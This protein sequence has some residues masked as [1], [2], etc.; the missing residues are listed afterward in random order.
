M[1]LKSFWTTS[2]RRVSPQRR[3][4]AASLAERAG[5]SIYQT[6]GIRI[7]IV[8]DYAFQQTFTALILKQLGHQVRIASDVLEALSALQLDHYDVILLDCQ[9]PLMSGAT[10]TRFIRTLARMKGQNLT[11][12]GISSTDAPQ[13]CFDAGMDD[14]VRKP[15]NKAILKAV[16]GRS[17]RHNNAH[18]NQLYKK[19]LTHSQT[20]K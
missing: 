5:K 13:E 6:H 18:M 20:S 2:G 8:E 17:V 14:I 9:M 3:S 16:L 7:L 19:E 1:A 15:V 4:A 11:I 10:A 12:I